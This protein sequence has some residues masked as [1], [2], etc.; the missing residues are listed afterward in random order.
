[1][2]L[3]PYQAALVVLIGNNRCLVGERLAS[4]CGGYLDRALDLTDE[5]EDALERLDDRYNELIPTD[6]RLQE[7]FRAYWGD[8]PD[9]FER[10]A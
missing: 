6:T 1:V 5:E 3:L 9:E 7:T 10:I 4:E 8:H 2:L